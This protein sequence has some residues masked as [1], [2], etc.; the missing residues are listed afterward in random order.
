MREIKPTRD[1]MANA[2]YSYYLY[3]GLGIEEIEKLAH[4][5]IIDDE[6]HNLL[7][8]TDDYETRQ[9]L[10]KILNEVRKIVWR[11]NHKV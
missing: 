6:I 9:K 1:E 4:L 11:K 8:I 2:F 7:E 3:K 5:Q 10:I